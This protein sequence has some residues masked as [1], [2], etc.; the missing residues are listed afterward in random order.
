MTA[1]E[2]NGLPETGL[3]PRA[4]A[5][6]LQTLDSKVI[7]FGALVRS[8]VALEGPPPTLQQPMFAAAG[9]V[10][11]TPG[12]ARGD[13]TP[14]APAAAPAAQ[15]PDPA[16]AA[17]TILTTRV[18]PTTDAGN[19]PAG[20]QRPEAG[21]PTKADDL[22]NIATRP[23]IAPGLEMPGQILFIAPPIRIEQL[24]PAGAESPAAGSPLKTLEDQKKTPDNIIASPSPEIQQ[25][26]SLKGRAALPI[27]PDTTPSVLAMPMLTPQPGSSPIRQAT[28]NVLPS[29]VDSKQAPLGAGPFAV[30]PAAPERSISPPAQNEGS[31]QQNSL[32]GTGVRHVTVPAPATTVNLIAGSEETTSHGAEAP[33]VLPQPTNFN[34]ISTVGSNDT[35]LSLDPLPSRLV[36][37]VAQPIVAAVT[38]T[39]HEAGQQQ[40]IIRL[41]PQE[42]GKVHIIV[43]QTKDG[44]ARVSLSVERPETLALLQRDQ[45]QLH[46]ALNRAGVQID[47]QSIDFSLIPQNKQENPASAAQS[48]SSSDN[49]FTPQ[50]G[51]MFQDHQRRQAQDKPS[52]E[53][54]DSNIPAWTKVD[55]AQVRATANYLITYLDG[56]GLDITA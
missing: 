34:P 39:T 8:A 5:V 55:T 37:Q 4:F 30:K 40:T 49:P 27:R 36:E 44:A 25:P 23:Q 46:K 10:A 42:L 19:A 26:G 15:S 52:T 11:S 45:P 20:D 18:L 32:L 38:T 21:K 51:S 22:H 6:R 2:T 12:P 50:S 53:S 1:L 17:Q 28:A 24:L 35:R 33:S 41:D 54:L 56:S 9:P 47:H 29:P 31:G 43:E 16:V 3:S 14:L 7:E 13:F 48:L